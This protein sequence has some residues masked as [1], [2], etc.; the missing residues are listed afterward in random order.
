MTTGAGTYTSTTFSW[1]AS[2][3][4]PSSY[5]ITG[6]DGAGNQVTTALSFATDTTAPTQSV[7]LTKV[8]GGVVLNGSTIYYKG[9]AAGSFTLTDTVSDAGSGPASALFPAIGTSGWTHNSETVTTGAGTYTSTTFSWNASPTNP[10]S[11]TITG[12][13]GAGN[14][15]TTALSFATDTTA[16]TQSVS[17]TK[18]TGGVVL[19]GST[20]YYKGNAA[21]SFTLTDTVSDAGSGPASPSSPPLAPPAG[22]TTARP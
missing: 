6:S 2:P 13:D 16:P 14:Q 15:V 4:N 18:V 3:T 9:N 21:G 19:N 17:L 1:N 22:R 7:S 12:S 10:S 8:T 5:T 11:Y 20:I